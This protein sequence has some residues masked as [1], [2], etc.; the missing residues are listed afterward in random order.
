MRPIRG[1]IHVAVDYPKEVEDMTLRDA[2]D[3]FKAVEDTMARLEQSHG[4]ITAMEHRYI[5]QR[6]GHLMNEIAKR[7]M[8]PVGN[9][10]WMLSE[11]AGAERRMGN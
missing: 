1:D 7:E 3:W 5:S 11:I 6:W 9:V 8:L 10:S 4:P 2:V